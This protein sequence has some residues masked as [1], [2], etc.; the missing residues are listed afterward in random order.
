MSDAVKSSDVKGLRDRLRHVVYSHAEL[1]EDKLVDNLID[2]IL[3]V[4]FPVLLQIRKNADAVASLQKR[5]VN[6]TPLNRREH[7]QAAWMRGY[8]QA[9]RDCKEALQ[10]GEYDPTTKIPGGQHAS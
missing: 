7:E 9:L 6:F 2:D 5:E 3:D 10:R 4:A 8:N 1:E